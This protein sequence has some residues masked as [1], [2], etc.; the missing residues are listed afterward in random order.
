MTVWKTRGRRGDA[1]EDLILISNDFYAS[2]GVARIDKAATP[3]TVVELDGKGLI[4]KAYFEK[5]ATIDFYGIVQG[6]YL[7][8]DAKETHQQSFPLKNI[9]EHQIIYMK[10]VSEQKGLAFLIVHFK[11]QDTYKLLPF[12][13][14]WTYHLNSKKGGRKSIPYDAIPE[15][16]IIKREKNGILMYLDAVNRYIDWKNAH[17]AGLK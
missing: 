6:I 8:F 12:E 2:H 7:T 14:L 17:S 10:E 9:H 11:H 13:I 3:I 1:L 4:T 15:E 16:L 5:K